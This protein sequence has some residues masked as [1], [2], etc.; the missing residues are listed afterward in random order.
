MT[1]PKFAAALAAAAFMALTPA[2][3]ATATPVAPSDCS[4]LHD[5]RLREICRE[6]N[7][8]M[9]TRTPSEPYVIEQRSPFADL[10]PYAG[11]IAILG[12]IAAGVAW[13]WH[14][15]KARSVQ[16]P[17]TGHVQHAVVYV[18]DQVQPDPNGPVVMVTD[19]QAP[20]AT[21]FAPE[22]TR[23]PP[24]SQSYVPPPRYV[25]PVDLTGRP[26]ASEPRPTYDDP[27]PSPTRP[28][29]QP[30]GDSNDPFSDL[31]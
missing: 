25:A 16:P 26:A 22:P 2:A 27:T 24:P 21:P 15:K 8:P 23:T 19:Q 31:F 29:A 11:G 12:I 4:T 28:T 5:S 17:F 3:V 10:L 1:A 7:T 18:S 6:I 14:R 30:S 20:P 9:P 13:D